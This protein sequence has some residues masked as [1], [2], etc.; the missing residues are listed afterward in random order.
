MCFNSP[1][2]SPTETERLRCCAEP[3]NVKN[4]RHRLF[5]LLYLRTASNK[6]KI[7]IYKCIH[8]YK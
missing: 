7:L 2:Q 6:K 5:F 3:F 8:L 1:V 4:K